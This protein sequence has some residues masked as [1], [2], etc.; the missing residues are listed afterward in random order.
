[1][2]EKT[3][4]KTKHGE[5]ILRFMKEKQ[6]SHITINELTDHFRDNNITI[7]TA[8]IYRQLDKLCEDGVVAKYVFDNSG[9]ACYEYI[10]KGENCCGTHCYHLKCKDCGKLIHLECHEMSPLAE[11]I[12][13]SHGFEIDFSKTVFFG[14]CADCKK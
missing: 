13:Q 6:G 7:G 9:S 2:A 11:H 14:T 3:Q 4:Y 10:G 12:R 5:H 8:T 1:M